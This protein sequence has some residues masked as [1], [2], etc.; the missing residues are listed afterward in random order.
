MALPP[1]EYTGNGSNTDFTFAFSYLKEA[2]ILVYVWEGGTPSWVLKTKGT[3]YNFHNP[4]TIR[5]TG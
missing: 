1:I 5:F 4:T 2:D 3:H